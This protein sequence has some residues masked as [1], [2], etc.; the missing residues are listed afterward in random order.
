[1]SPN[2]A[3]PLLTQKNFQDFC[4]LPNKILSSIGCDLLNKP[5]SIWLSVL[6][7][8][9][10]IIAFLSH[11]YICIYITKT[12]F[13]MIVSDDF[14]LGL[15]L[16]LISGFNYALFSILKAIT[17]FWNIKE[18]MEIYQVLREIFPETRKEKL[19]LR[20]RDYFWPKWILF[21]V[22]FYIGAVTFIAS[23]PLLEGV[24]LYIVSVFRVGWS[25][26]E[27][28]YFKLYEIQYGF[29]HHSVFAYIITYGMELMH[30]HF[31][32]T[33]IIC[34]DIWV[35]CFTL[36]LCMHFDYIA[37]ELQNYEPNE[38]AYVKDQEFIADLVKR[39]QILLNIGDGLNS[40]FGGLLLL[41]LMSIAA[42]LCCA[43]VYTLTQDL[44]REFIE[45]V[46]FLPIVIG[47]YF[48]ICYY[49]QQLI[50]KSH[51]VA[52]AAYNHSWYNGS[53]PY[54]KS[55]FI[56]I[57]RSQKEVEL[58]AL[59]FQPICLE[60]FKMVMGA[61]YRVFALLKETMF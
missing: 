27:F 52:D 2:S 50:I 20:V 7:K 12:M 59:G 16:R 37:R 46:A 56:I 41:M 19:M 13:N 25:R 6:K 53:K 15:L 31:M 36:Q 54:K 45:Y 8:C 35:L 60:A 23:S 28:G 61:T 29:D 17:F 48:L 30:A 58:N 10:S 3:N 55:I 51:S 4:N 14:E 1:M 49:G 11:A 34:S 47:Q 40:V 33:F 42:T 39:H 18:F 9:Y 22:Y 57:M 26:A 44:G 5:H 43:G 32:V 21:T 24:I 38:K